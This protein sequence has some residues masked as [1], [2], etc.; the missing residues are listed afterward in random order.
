[1]R[2]HPIGRGRFVV[3]VLSGCSDSPRETAREMN[4]ALSQNTTADTT[5]DTSTRAFAA[6]TPP[7]PAP[8]TP[9]ASG[10]LLFM[11]REGGVEL[12]SDRFT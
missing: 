4:P 7:T 3:A 8:E 6:R 12:A 5:R 2:A 11:A 9:G 10:M 1:M